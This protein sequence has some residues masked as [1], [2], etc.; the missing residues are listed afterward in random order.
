MGGTTEPLPAGPD[1]EAITRTIGELYP[2]T[3]VVQ[4]MGATFF[5]ARRREALAELRD[6]RHDGQTR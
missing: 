3:D 4:A 1:P 2:E 5:S 6:D